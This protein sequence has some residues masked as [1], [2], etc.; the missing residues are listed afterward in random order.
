MGGENGL[1]NRSCK[2]QEMVVLLSR[3]ASSHIISRQLIFQ[4]IGRGCSKRWKVALLSEQGRF[5][6]SNSFPSGS[7]PPSR[8]EK[9]KKAV[10]QYGP[11]VIIFHVTISLASLG[12]FYLLVS[13]GI[14]V[15]KLVENLPYVGEKMSSNS[16]ATGAS[17][18]VIAYAVHK[19]FAPV[20]ISITLGSVP[21][22]VRFL[23]SKGIL[24]PP[25]VKW[26]LLVNSL[27]QSLKI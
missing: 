13:S 7:Q 4:K 21:L 8:K 16:V 1:L 6:S 12:L 19:V 10:T 11:T 2:I 27:T 3:F 14:D 26:S 25:G 18:F 22:I 5:C 15:V 24:K 9:L 17:T 23:R 20:R